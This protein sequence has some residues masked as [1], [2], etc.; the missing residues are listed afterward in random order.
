MFPR[1]CC[2]TF[3]VF[4]PPLETKV[5]LH[6]FTV[7]T[8]NSTTYHLS[9]SIRKTALRNQIPLIPKGR[10]TKLKNFTRTLLLSKNRNIATFVETFYLTLLSL[11][12]QGSAVNA[13]W[14]ILLCYYPLGF[15]AICA[16]ITVQMIYI[17]VK[18]IRFHSSPSNRLSH[19]SPRNKFRIFRKLSTLVCSS[20]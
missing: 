11:V 15:C 18:M 8:P 10:T 4:K 9:K 2:S 12:F 14:R 13:R 20:F 16:S 1:V 19:C 3:C 17:N 7:I 5:V 6:R